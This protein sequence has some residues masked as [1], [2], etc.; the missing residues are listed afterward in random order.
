MRSG[1]IARTRLGWAMTLFF[2]IQSL[3]AYAVYGWFATLWRDAG[4][5]A[6]TAS[7][8]VGIVAGVSIPLS[9]VLPQAVA[10][11]GDQ[12]WVVML[13][14]ACYP[15]AYLGLI[16]DPDGLA[17]LWALALGHRAHDVPDRAHLHR[18]AHPHR[19][20]D[21]GAVGVDAVDRLPDGRARPVRGRRGPRGHRRLDGGAA[22]CSPSSPSRSRS[23]RC[24]SGARRTS[25][26]SCPD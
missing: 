9:F 23:S 17:V 14:I 4:F 18:A 10:R 16:W 20:R 15:V 11:P 24:T 26:T 13:V 5:G 12:R 22:S 7:A 21:G 25:R 2:G 8:L 3:M 19:R 6:G 1:D